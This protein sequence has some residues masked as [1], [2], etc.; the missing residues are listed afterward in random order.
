MEKD[1]MKERDA[2][3]QRYKTVF[4]SPDGQKILEDLMTLFHVR[5]IAKGVD[6]YDTY[7]RDGQRSVV[8]H[9]L[10]HLSL[11]LEQYRKLITKNDGADHDI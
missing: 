7:F 11:N 6:P 5:S 2:L 3:F 1:I 8:M 10:G 4:S 9:I